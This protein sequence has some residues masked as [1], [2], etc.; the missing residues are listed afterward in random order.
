MDGIGIFCLAGG[1][2]SSRL[3]GNSRSRVRICSWKQSDFI[4]TWLPALV[5]GSLAALK[6]IET[7]VRSCSSTGA[8]VSESAREGTCLSPAVNRVRDCAVRRRCSKCLGYDKITWLD[9][10]RD[11]LLCWRKAS[12]LAS[13]WLS[14]SGLSFWA[15]RRLSDGACPGEVDVAYS[16]GDATGSW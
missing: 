10:T 1:C 8:R 15:T 3:S 14:G 13:T 16:I 5:C 2:Q 9:G 6:A 12:S 11:G 4:G 7:Q